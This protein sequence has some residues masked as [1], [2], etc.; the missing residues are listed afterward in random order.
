M[1]KIRGFVLVPRMG[2]IRTFLP[3]NQTSTVI[4]SPRRR[5]VPREKR[6][7]KIFENSIYKA[8]GV[9]DMRHVVRR[10]AGRIIFIHKDVPSHC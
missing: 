10:S 1:N 3:L 4:T 9:M 2:M 8:M 7:E 6:M 5:R